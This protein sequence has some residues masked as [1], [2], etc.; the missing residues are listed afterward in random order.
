ML[1]DKSE[2][3]NFFYIQ[4]HSFKRTEYIDENLNNQDPKQ[5]KDKGE[6]L[7]IL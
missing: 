1:F 2:N 5:R 4:I 6:I 3:F 7:F